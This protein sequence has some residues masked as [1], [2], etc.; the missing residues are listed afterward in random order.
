M[1][2]QTIS[3]E[4]TILPQLG[5]KGIIKPDASGYYRVILGALNIHNSGKAWYDWES[6]KAVFDNSGDLMRRIK[7]NKCYS[8]LGHPKRTPGMSRDEYLQRILTI[9]E[10]NVT[11][12]IRKIDLIEEVTRA[13]GGRPVVVTYGEVKPFGPHGE[14]AEE[15][16][17]SPDINTCFSIRSITFDQ[18]DSWGR[19]VKKLMEVV[20]WDLVLEP[21]I[22]IATKYDNPSMESL[23]KTVA[24]MPLDTYLL[25]RTQN[26]MMTNGLGL[27]SND[28]PMRIL[29][30]MI[31]AAKRLDRMSTS[32][33]YLP[34]SAKW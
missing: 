20:N 9:Y 18:R 10:D 14:V 12:H 1:T 15:S 11:N 4:G 13:E 28:A 33:I 16:L 5:K 17:T 32:Q 8:E 19:L 6:S 34:P 29:T 23:T 27:E 24:S 30:R 7:S 22:E 25:Q 21:G 26:D 3:Y 31:D 2:Q